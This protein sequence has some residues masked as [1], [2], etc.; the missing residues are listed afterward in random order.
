MLRLIFFREWIFFFGVIWYF[1]WPTLKYFH[2]YVRSFVETKKRLA[3]QPAGHKSNI[4]ARVLN[5]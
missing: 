1:A 3:Q 4:S 5:R 2:V